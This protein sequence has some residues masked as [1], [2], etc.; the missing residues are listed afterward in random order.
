M[1]YPASSVLRVRIK[2]RTLARRA[3]VPR[4]SRTQN[5]ASLGVA[6]ENVQRIPQN[7]FLGCFL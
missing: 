7:S 6:H 4:R 3:A 5:F 2:S 1:R